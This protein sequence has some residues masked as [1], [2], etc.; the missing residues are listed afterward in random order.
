MT[1]PAVV[2]LSSEPERIEEMVRLVVEAVVELR[3]VA[4][5]FVLVALV[6]SVFPASVVDPKRFAKVELKAPVIVVE[7]ATAKVPAAKTLP[8]LLMVKR[9]EVENAV[10]VEPMEKICVVVV[11]RDEVGVA[12]IER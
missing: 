1:E 6:S 12:K 10:V 7:P 11:G 9:V 5:K 8:T 2:V 4:K 3:L